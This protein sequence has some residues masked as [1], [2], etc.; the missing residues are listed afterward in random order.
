MLL[1]IQTGERICIFRIYMVI[2]V[3][4]RYTSH[5]QMPSASCAK[6]NL[7]QLTLIIKRIMSFKHY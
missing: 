5:L 1:V 6:L 2:I 4:S 7:H 3:K